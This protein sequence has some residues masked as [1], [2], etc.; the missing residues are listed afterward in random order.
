MKWSEIYLKTLKEVPSGAHISS[1]ILL[2]RS[3]LI[4]MS[5]QGIYVYNT[6]FLRSLQKLSNLIKKELEKNQARE[7]LMPMVQSKEIWEESGRWNKFEGLLLKMES[8]TGAKLCL[9]PTH[10]E[11]IINFVKPGLSSW[12]D[13]PLNLYQIQTKY[14]DEI[15]PRFGLMRA[16]EFLMKDAYSFDTCFETA[17]QSYQKMFQAYQNIFNQ[18]EVDYVVVKADSGAIGGNHSEEFHIL[19][20]AGEDELLV[21]Q[22]M[23]ANIEI[24]PRQDAKKTQSSTPELKKMEKFA[25]PHIKTIDQLA[26]FLS[27]ESKELIKILFFINQDQNQASLKNKAFAVLCLGDDEVSLFKVK[28][29]LCLKEQPILA[30]K[31]AVYKITGVEPGSC[32]PHKLKIEVPIYLD[33]YLKGKRNFITGANEEGFHFKNVNIDRD[34]KVKAFGDF[35]FA[36][37]RD[38]SPQGFSFKKYRG[39]EVGHLF[40]LGD[41]YSKKMGLSYLD[42]KGKKQFVKMGCYGLGVTR[43]LQAI[44]EQK[45]D[46]KGILWPFC[47]APFA[48]HICLIDGEENSRISKAQEKLISILDKQSLDYFI[49]NRKERPGVKFKDADLIGLPLRVNLG[50]R[51]L[52]NNQIE[53]FVRKTG[54]K[55]K[56]NLSDL[57]SNFFLTKF[58]N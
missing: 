28:K 48:V 30:D 4:S 26:H 9:G 45:H 21:S 19:A 35:C 29:E 58:L 16:R 6:L 31:E 54:E 2:L 12:R 42:K 51:D 52:E 7:I 55:H 1:H 57:E 40:Y 18:L 49:D 53:I 34:F 27:I 46:D 43:T 8:R 38:L 36:R 41:E 39:I 23:S 20:K 13:M 5:S 3:G 22:D 24:C 14:R 44:I 37:E 10:E 17:F 47:I 11:L 25:T 56:V 15:R 32:G 50:L 33:N